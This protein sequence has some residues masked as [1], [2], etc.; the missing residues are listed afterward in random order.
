MCWHSF[1]TSSETQVWIQNCILY[2]ILIQYSIANQNTNFTF[3]WAQ[4][5]LWSQIVNHQKKGKDD[6][7]ISH[8]LTFLWM[9]VSPE[10]AP[11]ESLDWHEVKHYVFLHISKFCLVL[12]YW[13]HNI[14]FFLHSTCISMKIQCPAHIVENYE[15]CFDIAKNMRMRYVHMCM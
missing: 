5:H 8:C 4:N 1:L 15:D 11:S 12:T 9:L 6:G 2:F 10:V 7:F 3:T 14:L 13:C